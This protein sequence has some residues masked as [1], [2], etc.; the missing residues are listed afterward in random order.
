MPTLQQLQTLE[1]EAKEFAAAARE[2]FSIKDPTDAQK[3]QYTKAA[4]ELGTAVG[5]AGGKSAGASLI[6]KAILENDYEYNRGLLNG[7]TGWKSKNP[8]AFGNLLE[9]AERDADQ[10]SLVSI[11]GRGVPIDADGTNPKHDAARRETARILEG[12]F[13]YKFTDG[14]F[15]GKTYAQVKFKELGL[16][17]GE[18]SVDLIDD[19]GKLDRRKLDVALRIFQKDTGLEPDGRIGSVT[20]DVLLI[21]KDIKNNSGYAPRVAQSAVFGKGGA[22]LCGEVLDC[23]LQDYKDGADKDKD[24]DAR[25]QKARQAIINV[26]ELIEGRLDGI[27][28]SKEN[29]ADKNLSAKEKGALTTFSK[30]IDKDKNLTEGEIKAFQTAFGLKGDGIIGRETLATINQVNLRLA[31][32]EVIDPSEIK[33]A[34]QTQLGGHRP[35]GQQHS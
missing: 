22:Y 27:V 25:K 33:A 10:A 19:K 6:V 31:V 7:T 23:K 4:R 20:A 14:E 17:A 11:V 13:D 24:A 16:K 5:D 12:Y 28:V 1:K 8:Q 18:T 15:K 3:A 32:R 9:K 35:K 26:R 34:V 30:A 2:H 21:A 29:F